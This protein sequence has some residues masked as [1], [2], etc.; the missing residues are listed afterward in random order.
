MD[1]TAARLDLVARLGTLIQTVWPSAE[2]RPF[3]SMATEL[4]LPTSDVDIVILGAPS[5]KA[6]FLKLERV[7]RESQTTT[8]LE[9]IL[10]ARIPIIKLTDK[11]TAF[12][13]DIS[14]GVEGRFMLAFYRFLLW[15]W[16]VD[17]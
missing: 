6:A 4:Y 13:V 15:P 17:A 8:Y 11:L 1:E 7:I 3:G 16:P 5:D 2:V 14:I 10:S 9:A 12:A